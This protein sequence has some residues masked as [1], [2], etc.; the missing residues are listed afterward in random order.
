MFPMTAQGVIDW[1]RNNMLE[2]AQ[3]YDALNPCGDGL[4]DDYWINGAFDE[5]KKALKES[6]PDQDTEEFYKMI[7]DSLDDEKFKSFKFDLSHTSR[8]IGTFAYDGFVEYV[9]KAVDAEYM[10]ILQ[11]IQDDYNDE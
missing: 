11:G 5:L 3:E 10:G 8:T 7:I 2:V 9:L 6:I 1:T 4:S